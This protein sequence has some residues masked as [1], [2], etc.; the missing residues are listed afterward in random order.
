VGPDGARP[1]SA[2]D[3]LD[4]GQARRPDQTQP[5]SDNTA[6]GL[7]SGVPDGGG[8]PSDRGDL[9]A[10]AQVP[11]LE[12]DAANLEYAQQATDLV[13]EHLSDQQQEPDPELLK[14]LDWTAEE[15]RAFLDRWEALKRGAR[16]D[17]GN[18]DGELEDALRSLGLRDSG[19]G[20]RRSNGDNDAYRGLR[21]DGARSRPPA[22]IWEQF[23]A[24]RKGAARGQHRGE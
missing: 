12:G 13:L 19:P 1:D 8:I 17:A 3:P 4:P 10:K 9:P 16:E 18:A 14:S 6:G 7:S 22:S 21:D 23:N 24:Y 11:L 15:L 5:G 20:R 2:R